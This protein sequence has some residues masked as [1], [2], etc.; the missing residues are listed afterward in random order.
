MPTASVWM[1]RGSLIYLLAAM[2]VGA[3]LLVHKAVY[4]HP[5]VW[6]LLPLHIE[7]AL[8]GWIIQLTMGTAYWIFPRFLE[9]LPRG[10]PTYIWAAAGLFNLGIVLNGVSY[11]GLLP[12]DTFLF[13]R[14]FQVV[15]VML[16]VGQHWKRVTT[17]RK[18]R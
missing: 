13:G 15:A 6:Q 1:I 10:N 7:M 2:L 16:F 8:F 18:H 5:S 4:L 9:G 12:E 11:L 3:L 14:I 17:Y